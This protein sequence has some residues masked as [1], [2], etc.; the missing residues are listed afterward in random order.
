MELMG[1]RQHG[2]GLMANGTEAPAVQYEAPVERRS[3]R[4]CPTPAELE[5]HAAFVEKLKEPVWNS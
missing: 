4:I 1:G 2:L 5:K 3:I